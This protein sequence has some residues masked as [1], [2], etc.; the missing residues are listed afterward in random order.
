[1][2]VETKPIFHPEVIR[3]HLRMFTLPESVE[4]V[5][6]RLQHGAEL[7]SSGKADTFRETASF[8]LADV[9]LRRQSPHE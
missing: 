4:G 5:R 1:M 7:I 3:Q 8:R 9:P 2:A 6:P